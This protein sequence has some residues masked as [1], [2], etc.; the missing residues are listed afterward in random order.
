MRVGW[1]SVVH[2]GNSLQLLYGLT[3][4]IALAGCVFVEPGRTFQE[5]G[6][7]GRPTDP[8]NPPPAKLP[9]SIIA[10]KQSSLAAM[11]GQEVT[12]GVEASDPQHSPLTFA[13]SSNLGALGVAQSAATTSL[14][15]WVAPP[16]IP[17]GL[18]PSIT[19]TAA[20]K[21]SLS[22]AATFT[23]GGVLPC[24]E[25]EDTIYSEGGQVETV[26]VPPGKSAVMALLWG[27]GGGGGAPAKGGGGAWIHAQFPVASGDHL[28]IRVAS[29]GAAYGGG[30]GASYV[31][32]NGEVMLVVAGGGG[33]GIDGCSGCTGEGG[34]HSQAGM[35]GAGGPAGS[36][37]QDG[38][39][40]NYFQT[41]SGPGSGGTT[42]AGG[43]AGISNDQSPY[44]P[45]TSNGLSGSQDQGGAAF[46][47][48]S[49]H[50]KPAMG[51]LGGEGV[52]NG[53]GGGGGSGKFGGGSG[54][55]KWTY[56]GGGG[57][58]GASWAHPSATLLGSEGGNGPAPGG[59]MAAGY[60]DN[61]G[62]GGDPQ[63]MAFG[64][65]PTPGKA[66]LIIIKIR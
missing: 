58:G 37:G 15:R 53:S 55:S 17:S 9:P 25:P 39:P 19:V 50:G 7:D 10:T 20:N 2:M 22:A 45:C 32:R 57:G 62:Q 42:N 26:V 24:M 41:N 14:V 33:A 11:P 1:H 48:G 12:F 66:G 38:Q 60:Q 35:G 36:Q 21:L 59:A 47:C 44:G 63:T 16:C 30:G 65:A 52:G 64:A 34:T 40:N 3:Y 23:V 61:A 54:A 8:S 27:A 43:V 29:G 28:E 56:T 49:G 5:G 6:E 18:D 46:S 31:L 4:S 51:H 13:W